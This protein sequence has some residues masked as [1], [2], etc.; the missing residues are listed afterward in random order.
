M[1][2]GF[3]SVSAIALRTNIRI[4]ETVFAHHGNLHDSY[5]KPQFLISRIYQWFSVQYP[6]AQ[7]TILSLSPVALH[8]PHC[9]CSYI[10]HRTFFEPQ[11]W[12]II[13]IQLLWIFCI[14]RNKVCP[15]KLGKIRPRFYKMDIFLLLY[16][17]RL[18]VSYLRSF[19]VKLLWFFAIG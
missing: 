12:Q 19:V 3:P 11:L 17:D 2:N 6:H 4:F 13:R 18:W 1:F 16:L 5:F 14:L 7:T 9:F 10:F 15:I 8:S